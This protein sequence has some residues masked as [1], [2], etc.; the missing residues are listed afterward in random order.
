MESIDKMP[1]SRQ[2]TPW[3]Q[4][5]VLAREDFAEVGLADVTDADLAV[6][7]SHD[8]D[9]A[10]DNLEVEPSVEFILARIVNKRDGNCALGKNP[11]TLHLSYTQEAS[12]IVL[13]LSALRKIAIPKDIL[14]KL[15]PSSAYQIAEPVYVLSSWL[16]LR[17]NRHAFPNS[18]VERLKPVFSRL[19]EAGKK[20]SIG[21]LSFRILYEP[22]EEL[23][24]DEE[25]I[26][27]LTI[28]YIADR[29][30]CGRSCLLRWEWRV[31]EG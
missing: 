12:S 18:L 13:E 24:P 5:T 1:W 14:V 22:K 20:N 6:A 30:R 19:E 10:N 17:Y 9:I 21:I 2:S 4:G 27:W 31:G 25:Y 3:K 23:S 29:D 28:V 11:R 16:A 26:L 15:Q 8:C 7:I